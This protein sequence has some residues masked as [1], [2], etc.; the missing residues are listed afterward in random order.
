MT[1]VPLK[2]THT[3]EVRAT[4]SGETGLDV[5]ESLVVDLERGLRAVVA[6]NVEHSD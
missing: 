5:W 4:D 1:G 3:H 6:I 2:M